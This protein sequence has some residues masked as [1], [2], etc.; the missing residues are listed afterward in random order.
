MDTWI[1]EAY[2]FRVEE[3]L[4]GSE[5]FRSDL[6]VVSAHRNIRLVVCG[7]PYLELLTVG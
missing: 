3:D 7:P 6:G 2:D 4:R 1:F 5:P